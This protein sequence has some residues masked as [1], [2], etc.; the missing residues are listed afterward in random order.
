MRVRFFLSED[1]S[2]YLIKQL[3]FQFLTECICSK[4]TFF[5]K[6]TRED[7]LIHLK[8][9]KLIHCSKLPV[10]DKLHKILTS[11][12]SFLIFFFSFRLLLLSKDLSFNWYHFSPLEK[13]FT[14]GKHWSRVMT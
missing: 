8:K 7:K 14:I 3:R 12:F 13:D 5:N 11:F 1:H 9:G 10:A 6:K 4:T 2:M